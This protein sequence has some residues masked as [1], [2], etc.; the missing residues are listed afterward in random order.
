MAEASPQIK[1]IVYRA[2]ADLE[3]QWGT[4]QRP[5]IVNVTKLD[6]HLVKEP[7]S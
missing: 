5:E 2:V 1:A 4:A 3:D 6:Q 7:N